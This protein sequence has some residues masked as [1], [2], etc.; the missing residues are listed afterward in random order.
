MAV[1]AVSSPAVEVPGVAVAPAIVAHERLP[2]LELLSDTVVATDAAGPSEAQSDRKPQ[3]PI[4]SAQTI[5]SAVAPLQRPP[6]EPRV[7]TAPELVP[8]SPTNKPAWIA[9]AGEP[10]APPV[11]LRRPAWIGEAWERQKQAEQKQAEA[12][13]RLPATTPKPTSVKAEA[14]PEATAANRPGPF[15]SLGRDSP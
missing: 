9:G 7:S 11:P 4:E 2:T 3:A 10:S 13:N 14:P 8:P 12:R 6:L 15:Q 1:A 5:A